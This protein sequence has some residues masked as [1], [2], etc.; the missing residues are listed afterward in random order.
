MTD[1]LLL[2][3]IPE[4]VRGAK[5]LLDSKFTYKKALKLHLNKIKKPPY[6]FRRFFFLDGVKSL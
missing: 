5:L 6:N 4:I 1:E 2:K 3:K